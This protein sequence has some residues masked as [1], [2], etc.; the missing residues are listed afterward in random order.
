MTA[1]I[2][3]V[4]YKKKVYHLHWPKKFDKIVLKA[5]KLY[6]RPGGTV[7]WKE[8]EAD[9]ML[10]GL[11]V[12]LTLRNI[13]QR[14][15]HLKALKKPGFKKK[16]LKKN[17][18]YLKKNLLVAASGNAQKQKLY[19]KI[20]PEEIKKKHGWKPRT[21]WTEKQRELLLKLSKLYRK[22]KVTVD[23]VD[24]A[25]DKRVEK[26]PFQDS[27]KLCK[28]Y[29]SLKRKKEGGKKYIKK[30]REEALQ[31]KYDNYD[32]YLEN[33]EKRRVRVKKAVNEFLLS[34]LELR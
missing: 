20:V 18:A 22:S 16:R 23:W 26:L 34:K 13:A 25:L 2:M 17:Q 33:Q 9:G 8:A 28:Y 24:L 29:N 4:T 27:L 1:T 10:K 14:N 3:K 15:G 7:S 30:R 21:I 5:A 19:A 12:F 6:K 32:T 11:P 31:Y